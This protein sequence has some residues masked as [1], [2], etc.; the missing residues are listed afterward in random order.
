[1]GWVR[2]DGRGVEME[3]EGEREVVEAF[4][5]GIPEAGPPLAVVQGV[6]VTSVE[7]QGEDG[8]R[9]LES[10][11]AGGSGLASTPPDVAVCDRCL[12]ELLDP[13]DR[14]YRYPFINCTDCGPR[15]T[16]IEETPYDRSR[17]SMRR[18]EM[19]PACRVEYDDPAS[20]RF[21]A[22]PNACPECGPHVT[23]VDAGGAR[24]DDVHP[25]TSALEMLGGG[26]IVAIRGP[27]GFHLACDARE[28]AA[29]QRLRDRK[30]R[31]HQPFAVM[32]RDLAVARSLAEVD[33]G[34]AHLLTSWRRPIV[35]L[36]AAGGSP[37]AANVC[38]DV[39]RV[40]V[41]LP[42]TPLQH[43]LLAGSAD[44]L[45][46][47]SGNPS[48]EPLI[49]T[50][51]IALDRL[52]GVADVF[53]SSDL[54]T[55]QRADDS[56]IL[57]SEDGPVLV[58]RSRG[59]TPAPVP[60]P[61]GGPGV[62]AVGGDLKNV[63]CATRGADAYLGQHVGDLEHPDAVDLL[64]STLSHLRRLTHAQPQI[65]VHDLH[66][67]YHSTALASRLAREEGLPT[68]AVQHHHAHALAVL[69]EHGG[70]GPALALALD[71]TGYGDDGTVW[72]G[73]LLWVHGLRMRRLGHLA[74]LPLP[75][76]DRATEQPW[77]MGLAA[78]HRVLGGVADP[79]D[80]AALTT[81]DRTRV[82]GVLQLLDRGDVLPITTSCGRLFDAVASLLG[83]RQ[84]ASYEGQAAVELEGVAMQGESR[85]PGPFDLGA[86][87]EGPM[88][89]D[90]G[91]WLSTWVGVE[92]LDA[93]AVARA[94]HDTL[95]AALVEATLR[96]AEHTGVT[97][98]ALSGGAC[99]NTLLMRGL[100]GGL[101]REGL[102]VFT[103]A[104]VPPGDGGL[105]LGQAW[106]GVLSLTRGA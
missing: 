101:R 47:T 102:R 25:I 15:Y 41:M 27:G 44:A 46:M 55:A 76:G 85:G 103:A 52:E 54:P 92:H 88:A 21:H 32:A 86:T 50:N 24:L 59:Y 38:G 82:Q 34:M 95:V 94:F 51:E 80:L 57:A 8:F 84:E 66:P 16:L 72:G 93:P 74:P 64:A 18:F 42:W 62:L 100:V 69:A 77:R 7:A 58:R 83:V 49:C 36:E 5:E 53:L 68:L 12:A 29:V 28:P 3:V 70:C 96:A 37:L 89:I 31:P 23:L 106:A 78:A 90:L 48:G 4:V 33:D 91:P 104:A 63:P 81:V 17:T 79:G 9:I 99:V 2:N 20:R 65:V 71:G 97:D 45:V 39:P 35:L 19:C 43:L 11:M 105:A 73:E 22:Q 40:G 13:A 75:G 6:E 30:R 60:L 67:D 26:R 14:R 56:V 1:M 61:A 98:V 87:A 10:P